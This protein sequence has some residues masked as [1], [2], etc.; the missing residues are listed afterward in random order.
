MIDYAPAVVPDGSRSDTPSS[1]SQNALSF[2][3][4]HFNSSNCLASHILSP[5]VVCKHKHLNILTTCLNGFPFTRKVK[6]SQCCVGFQQ[7]TKCCSSIVSDFITCLLTKHDYSDPKKQET[8]TYLTTQ[9]YGIQCCVDFQCIGQCLDSII[10][11][12]IIYSSTEHT[13]LIPN[14]AED[15]STYL[16]S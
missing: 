9:A 16:T 13:H 1:N 5:C 2:S 15:L 10:T 12:T 8:S 6:V 11:N 14:H 7:F 3:P 4:Y